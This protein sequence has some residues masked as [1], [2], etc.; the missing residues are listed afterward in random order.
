MS[1]GL[2]HS[3]PG[4]PLWTF[5]GSRVH[6]QDPLPTVAFLHTAGRTLTSIYGAAHLLFHRFH[7]PTT[8]T[9]NYPTLFFRSAG[10]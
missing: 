10:R 8:V 7:S 3:L 9:K 1:Y 4:T 6:L 2:F 5:S